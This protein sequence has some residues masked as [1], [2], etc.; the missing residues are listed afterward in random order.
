MDLLELVDAVPTTLQGT[1]G[2]VMVFAVKTVAD[3]IVP[4]TV[5]LNVPQTVTVT[6]PQT[7][8]VNVSSVILTQ[9]A[10]SEEPP[11]PHPQMYA[12]SSIVLK[13]EPEEKFRFRYKS[14]MQG[15]HGCIHGKYFTKKDKRYPTI[16]VENVPHGHD[17]I[18][19]RVGL[20]SAKDKHNHHVHKLMWKQ[21]SKVEEDFVE[22]EVHRS[23]G[24]VQVM[25]GLGIIHTSRRHVEETIFNR[26]K[27]VYLEDKCIRTMN[28]GSELTKAE[29]IHLKEEA[30]K[31]SKTMTD[32]MNT[33]ILGFEVFTVSNGIH[34]PLCEPLFTQPIKNLKNPTTGDLKITRMSCLS[35]SV[36]GGDEVFIF[37]ERVIKGNIKVRFFKENDEEER[38]WEELAIFT[39]NDVH[40]QYAIAFKTPSYRDDS[41]TESV[42][43]YF[44][45]YRP[46]DE[47]VSEKKTFRFKPTDE[48]MMRKR[49]RIRENMSDISDVGLLAS[50]NPPPRFPSMYTENYMNQPQQQQVQQRQ[51][52]SNHNSSPT[53]PNNNHSSPHN[54]LSSPHQPQYNPHQTP[55]QQS[56][57]QA[58]NHNHNHNNLGD[59]N[60]Y[61]MEDNQAIDMDIINDLCRDPEYVEIVSRL[62]PFDYMTDSSPPTSV[63]H[64]RGQ[65]GQPRGQPIPVGGSIATDSAHA[66]PQP[67][68]VQMVDSIENDMAGPSTEF[69]VTAVQ[70]AERLSFNLHQFRTSGDINL[71][72]EK[73]YN[74]LGYTT[75]LGNNTLHMAVVSE[76]MDA[77]A[78]ILEVAAR[79]NFKDVLEERNNMGDTALHLAIKRGKLEMASLLLKYQC[80]P[81]TLDGSGNTALHLAVLAV[82]LAQSEHDKEFLNGVLKYKPN[83][84]ITNNLGLFPLHVAVQTGSLPVVMALVEAG[85]DVDAREG[86][87]GQTPLHVALA[88]G[89]RT[90]I[91][92]LVLQARADPSVENFAGKNCMQVADHLG[93]QE[94]MRSTTSSKQ[95]RINL[96][97]L[98]RLSDYL[99]SDVV[100]EDIPLGDLK[101]VEAE[102]NNQGKWRKLVDKLGLQEIAPYLESNPNPTS[103]LIKFLKEKKSK[104]DVIAEA[105]ANIIIK[106]ENN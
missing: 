24:F 86:V 22:A 15:T 91:E 52:Q 99:Q 90:I 92:Y 10:K 101:L 37:T 74:L 41:V 14:E 51:Q 26:K 71:V 61:N 83:L 7:L 70:I 66:R 49:R 45:L 105:L 63:S 27:K 2:D 97:L 18:K 28:P 48:T 95:Y 78:Y 4:K 65:I 73:I 85:H 46:S 96:E 19:V 29:E 62:S 40:H 88:H 87:A 8:N 76:E 30:K 35:G 9:R 106:E 102:L 56:Q 77:L 20:Y 84:N 98:A 34:Y 75:K 68:P 17:I 69:T 21:F 93:I 67:R 44:E 39:E 89:N 23:K 59:Q 16:K 47:A 5:S 1:D 6:V 81:N 80:S 31:M 58:P 43:V 82:H 103:L 54:N 60:D 104:M 33:V 42:D 53:S 50:I 13:E 55:N 36:L 100:L 64:L 38:V 11:S 12:E 79:I 94:V 32:K 25:Q 3:Q 57:N 72:Y